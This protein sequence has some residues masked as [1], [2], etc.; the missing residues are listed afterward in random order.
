MESTLSGLKVLLVDDEELIREVLRI[1]LEMEGMIVEEACDGL[2]AFNLLIVNQYDFLISDIRM[3]NCD[4]I[5][6]LEK[7]HHFDGHKPKIFMMTAYSSL[8][9]SA[10]KQKGVIKILSKPSD[11]E[12]LSDTLKEYL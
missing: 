10:A 1:Q 5:E 7:L 11:V 12:S 6:L 4:G 9:E 3:P 8:T 2:E